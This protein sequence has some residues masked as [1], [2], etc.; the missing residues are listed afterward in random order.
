M[1]KPEKKVGP[2]IK[3]F[4]VVRSGGGWSFV[5]ATVQDGILKE[6]TFK[7]P[8]VKPIAVE[9]FKLAASKEFMRVD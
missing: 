2:K 4:G 7:E 3:L 5:E 9:D 1:S 6:I 8:N